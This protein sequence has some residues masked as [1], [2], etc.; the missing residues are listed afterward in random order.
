MYDVNE[1]CNISHVEYL[2]SM[3][4]FVSYLP[5]LLVKVFNIQQ[6]RILE[7]FDPQVPVFDIKTTQ[8]EIKLSIN[9]KIDKRSS[10]LDKNW[11]HSTLYYS[12]LI[13]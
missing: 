3:Y 12:K 6:V 8:N 4:L 2:L 5:E 7:E 10:K 11:T 13:S 9:I 1:C